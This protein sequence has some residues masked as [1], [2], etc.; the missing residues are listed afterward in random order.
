MMKYLLDAV[1]ILIF[2]LCVA[3]GRKR[4]FVKTVSGIVALVAALAVSSL[5]CTPV[6][7]YVYDKTIEPSIIET[8]DTQMEEV[9]GSATEKLVHTYESLPGVV[10]TLLAQSGVDS[11]EQFALSVPFYG[12]SSV[13]QEIAAMI[14]PILLP[15]VSALSSLVLFLITYIAA[16]L[17]LRMLNIVAKL[18]LLKQVN[19]TL[20]TIGGIVAG[21]LWALVSVTVIQL[22]AAFGIADGIITL[23]TVSE[24]LLTNWLIGINPLGGALVGILDSAITK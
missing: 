12:T 1:V 22:I 24:T 14:R 20:G 19:K 17:I 5:F 18:P 10:K 15:L 3:I 23:Q 6:A 16:T 2:L 13:P 8:V 4:G 11:G 21:A 7:E 9:K